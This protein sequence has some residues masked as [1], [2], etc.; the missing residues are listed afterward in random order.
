VSAETEG[1]VMTEAEKTQLMIVGAQLERDRIK[2]ISELPEAKGRRGTALALALNTSMAAE[3]CATVLAGLPKEDDGFGGGRDP[4]IGLALDY[5]DGPMSPEQVAAK[6][7][8]E[9]AR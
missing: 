2:A 8:S 7:N 9:P 6:V 5:V 3:A 1:K 4:R